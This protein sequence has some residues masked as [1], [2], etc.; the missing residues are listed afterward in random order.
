MLRQQACQSAAKE[1]E[2]L[3]DEARFFEEKS[4]SLKRLGEQM[5]EEDEK[6]KPAESGT[7]T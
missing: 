6:Q 1:R 2:R 5:L 3:L 4:L 7:Q